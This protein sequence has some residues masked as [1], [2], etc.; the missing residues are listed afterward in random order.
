MKSEI[1]NLRKE[2]HKYPEVSSLEVETANRIKRFIKKHHPTKIIENIDNHG[3]AVV[4]NFGVGG[5]TILIRCELDALPIQEENNISYRSVNTGISH[6]CG[7]DGHMAIV[8]GLIFWIKEQ[9]FKSGKIVLLFQ[10]A[11]ETGKGAYNVINDAKFKT[12]KPDYCFALH[13]IPKEP[14]HTIISLKQGFSAE[15]I[16]FALDIKGKECH[17]AEPENG[18]NPALVIAKIISNLSALNNNNPEDNNFSILTPVHIKMGEKSY[19]IS[20]AKASI[21]YTIRTWNTEVMN[22]LKATIETIVSSE[23]SLHQVGYKLAWLEHFPASKNNTTCNNLILKAA[24]KQNFN[25]Q[26]RKYPFKFGE[27]FGWFS[28]TYKTAMF[29]IGAGLDCKPLHN[30]AYNFPD[31]ILETGLKMFQNLITEVLEDS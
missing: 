4:Y 24:K 3:L 28:K 21:H 5:K 13:N 16:S 14:L 31:E 15:V 27:D 7:H 25:I 1:I 8:A 23:T 22:A 26:E 10:P 6:K 9:A 30:A 12:L 11:E 17:A 18:T 20:P 29:G 19:G 2:L